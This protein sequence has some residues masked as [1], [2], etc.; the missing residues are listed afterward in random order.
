MCTASNELKLCTCDLGEEPPEDYWI[1][2]GY[3][4]EKLQYIMGE[5]VMLTP[6]VEK[7][8]TFGAFIECTLNDH[9]C[10]DVHLS[11]QEGDALEIRMN[12][13]GEELHF[14][15]KYDNGAWVMNEELSYFDLMNEFDKVSEGIPS[16]RIEVYFKECHK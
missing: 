13:A 15:Y 4:K 7:Q 8:L 3:N 1:L 2:Y 12:S 16:P 14:Y 10:F 11:I 6:D 9:N 5:L